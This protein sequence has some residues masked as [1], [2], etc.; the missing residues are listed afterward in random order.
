VRDFFR[1]EF[2]NRLD[3]VLVF[4][5]LK[6]EEIRQIVDVQIQRLAKHLAEQE[7]ALEVTDGAKDELARQGW[8]EEYGA[9]PLKR[10]IQKNVQNALADA[11]LAG[12]IQRGDVAVVDNSGEKF[13]VSPRR[14][15][16]P[17]SAP[18][19]AGT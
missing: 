1:P 6:R 4:Q 16:K 19:T 11:I 10:A 5:P 17:E 9:R 15:A 13:W 3:E 8:S 12:R 2:L 14:A 18:Q 7:I